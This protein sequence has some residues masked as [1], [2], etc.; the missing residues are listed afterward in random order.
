MFS[1]IE[2][3]GLKSGINSILEISQSTH[4][5]VLS[6]CVWKLQCTKTKKSKAF[7][8]IVELLNNLKQKAYNV[9]S[10]TKSLVA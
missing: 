2:T 4:L 8:H 7:I 6:F 10:I 9:L 5:L 1:Q 3:R